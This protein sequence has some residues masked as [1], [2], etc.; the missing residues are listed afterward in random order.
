MNKSILVVFSL[1]VVVTTSVLA[2]TIRPIKPNEDHVSRWNWFVDAVHALHK[3]NI[4][5]KDVEIETT[6]GGYARLPKFYQKKKYIDKK[7]GRHLSSVYWETEKPDLLHSIEVYVYDN[8]NRVIRDFAGSFLTHSRAA[9]QQTLI[10]LHAYNNGLHAYRTFD[11]TDIRIYESCKGK[12]RGKNIEISFDD[13]E[14]LE[15]ADEPKSPMTTP[16]YKAC[17]KGLPTK[18][19]GKYLTPQ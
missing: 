7:T 2:D 18:S 16:I 3:K 8:K 13:M 1:M 9:P 5:G 10:S 14:I 17:F 19:A 4:K 12:Y 15:Y 6:T 11:A